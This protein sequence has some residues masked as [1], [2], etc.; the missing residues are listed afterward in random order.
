MKMAKMAA[1]AAKENEKRQ[2]VASA[3][4]SAN[5]KR[6]NNGGEKAS[7][8]WRRRKNIGESG[9]ESEIMAAAA[10]YTACSLIYRNGGGVKTMA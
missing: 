3:G 2:L 10:K 8:A 5:G 7:S 6:A 4:I 9:N 1:G